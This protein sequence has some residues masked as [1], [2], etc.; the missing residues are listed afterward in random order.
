MKSGLAQVH[1]SDPGAIYLTMHDGSE[2]PTFTVRHSGGAKWHL[3]PKKRSARPVVEKIHY[4]AADFDELKKGFFDKMAEQAPWY[5]PVAGVGRAFDA[6][7]NTLKHLGDSPVLSGLSGAVLGL[8]YDQARRHLYNT[9]QENEQETLGQRAARMLIPAVAMG[10]TGGVL[11]QGF[12]DAY[13]S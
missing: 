9:G 2:N 1:R 3:V 10:G 6:T 5:D 4:K 7:G 8:A 11:H 12:P 13:K